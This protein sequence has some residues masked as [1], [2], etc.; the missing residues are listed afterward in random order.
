MA[1]RALVAAEA[2]ADA[3][4]VPGAVPLMA[5]PR[6]VPLSAVPAAGDAGGVPAAP[7]AAVPVVGVEDACGAD[8][9]V[10]DAPMVDGASGDDVLDAPG[11]VSVVPA[12]GVNAAFSGVTIAATS[13][14]S[15]FVSNRG[16]QKITA[17]AAPAARPRNTH[18]HRRALMGWRRAIFGKP[19][20]GICPHVSCIGPA[21]IDVRSA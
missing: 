13:G 14:G 3:G 4:N 5:V 20:S 8:R 6:A 15:L 16:S 2:D 19:S 10:S 11:L 9:G 17:A 7:D 1:V 21:W 18:G 12:S